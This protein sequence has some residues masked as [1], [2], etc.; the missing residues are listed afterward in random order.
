[1]KIYLIYVCLLSFLIM[2]CTSSQKA[3]KADDAKEN[4]MFNKWLHH[5]KSQ[6]INTWGLPDSTKPDGRGGEVLIY[7]EGIDFKSVMNQKYTGPQYSFRKE[8]YVNADSTIYN[9]KAWR[10]K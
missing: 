7:K 8:M 10:K 2:S 5:R 4:A 3:Q 1:M 6:L 9:W